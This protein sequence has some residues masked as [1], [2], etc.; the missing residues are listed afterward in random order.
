[1]SSCKKIFIYQCLLLCHMPW[2]VRQWQTDVWLVDCAAVLCFS[3]RCSLLPLWQWNQPPDIPW[4]LSNLQLLRGKR[5]TPKAQS[6]KRFCP[7]HGWRI[8]LWNLQIIIPPRNSFDQI[9]MKIS[10][11]SHAYPLKNR[12]QCYQVFLLTVNLSNLQPFYLIT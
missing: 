12:G 6:Y 8:N 3:W 9:E 4:L 11:K 2:P 7:K 5:K 10:I 1:M